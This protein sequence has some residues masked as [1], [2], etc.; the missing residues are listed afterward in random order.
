MQ[1]HSDMKM[2]HSLVRDLTSRV[3]LSDHFLWTGQFLKAFLAS[4]QDDKH[5]SSYDRKF[6]IILLKHTYSLKLFFNFF[7]HFAKVIQLE[8]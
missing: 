7:S 8:A 6:Y 2:C 4:H 5:G 1:L 3:I